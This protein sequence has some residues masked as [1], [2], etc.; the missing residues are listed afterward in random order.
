MTI[1]TWRVTLTFE[2]DICRVLLSWS[3]WLS[4][5]ASCFACLQNAL[6]RAGSYRSVGNMQA[7]LYCFFGITLLFVLLVQ[8]QYILQA[9][10]GKDSSKVL[11]GFRGFSDSHE[12]DLVQ[13]VLCCGCRYYSHTNITDATKLVLGRVCNPC[14]WH[15]L[16]NSY[17]QCPDFISIAL[18]H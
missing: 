1:L 11:S 7:L 14:W 4:S 2:N 15:S 16:K 6:C 12:T 3:I 9:P 10:I 17:I 13:P 8:L 18:V 5:C